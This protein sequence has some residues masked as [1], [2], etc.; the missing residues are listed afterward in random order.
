[1]QKNITKRLIYTRIFSAFLAIYLL[2]M[3][4]FSIFVISEEQKVAGMEFR[5]YANGV[6]NQVADVLKNHI[7]ANNHVMDLVPLKKELIRYTDHFIMLGTEVAVF[8]G[9]YQLLFNTN[10]YWICRFPAYV[11]GKRLMMQIT[12]T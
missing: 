6:N 5:T 11:E 4:G 7:D 8:T 1:M 12:D 2:L 10:D 9:D 3:T